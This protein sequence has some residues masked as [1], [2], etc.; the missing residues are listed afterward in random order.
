M[1]KLLDLNTLTEHDTVAID[2]HEYDII[3]GDE[4]SILD[5]HRV[6]RWGARIA[7]IQERGCGSDLTEEEIADYDRLLDLTCRMILRAP[8]EVHR[9][10]GAMQRMSIVN[11]FTALPRPMA[12]TA[13]EPKAPPPGPAPLE[14]LREIAADM[15]KA[16]EAMAHQIVE[17]LAPSTGETSSPA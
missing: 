17:E 13:G 2:G 5:Y 15:A 9:L 1:A 10:L 7:E 8:D 16:D 12:P 11:C 4:L 14:A 3:R 6:A